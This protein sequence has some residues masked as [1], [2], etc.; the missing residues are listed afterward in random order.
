MTMLLICPKCKNK[1]K[2]QPLFGPIRDKR[3]RCVYCGRS[4]KISDYIIDEQA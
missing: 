1:M 4:F 2:Y 3:K